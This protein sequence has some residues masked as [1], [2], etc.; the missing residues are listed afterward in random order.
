MF[1]AGR[2]ACVCCSNTKTTGVR[3]VTI[4][5]D[6]KYQETGER[7][8]LRGEELREKRR[9]GVRKRDEMEMGCTV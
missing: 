8:E 7:V 2:A 9:G 1:L 6:A 3:L 5:R 4:Q